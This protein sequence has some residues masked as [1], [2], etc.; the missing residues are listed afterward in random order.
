MEFPA[1]RERLLKLVTAASAYTNVLLLSG[2]VHRAEVS[3][4]TC[5]LSAPA[6]SAASVSG[7]SNSGTG[8]SSGDSDGYSANVSGGVA[9]API[10]AVDLWELTSSGLS[11]TLLQTTNDSA[12]TSNSGGSGDGDV[13]APEFAGFVPVKSRG[14]IVEVFERLYQVKE[15]GL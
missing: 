10:V 2:D 13:S 5:T 1:A 3:R 12:D 4:A 14:I 6:P 7:G 9:T 11:H 15:H 8:I